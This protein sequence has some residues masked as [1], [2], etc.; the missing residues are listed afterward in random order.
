MSVYKIKALSIEGYMCFGARQVVHFPQDPGVYRVDG[1]NHIEPRLGSNG[2][3]KTK[4]LSAVSWVRYGKTT[5]GV[6]GPGIKSWLRTKSTK[7][8]TEVSEEG[9][10]N[11]EP[12]VIR[13]V[14]EPNSLSL[15]VGQGSEPRI[16]DQK[17]LDTF[18]EC[19]YSMFLAM[20][21]FPSTGESFMTIGQTEQGN[22]LSDVL[23]LDVWF[24]RSAAASKAAKEFKRKADEAEAQ[25]NEL[26]CRQAAHRA[27]IIEQQDL[28]RVHEAALVE[29]RQQDEARLERLREASAVK[30]GKRPVLELETPAGDAAVEASKCVD[31]ATAAL[32]A[33]KREAQ[34]ARQLM[35]KAAHAFEE[36][37]R[38]P[39]SK[40]YAC[41][42][43][44]GAEK[45]AQHTEKFEAAVHEAKTILSA[46]ERKLELRRTELAAAEAKH[47]EAAERAQQEYLE[48]QEARKEHDDLIAD[49]SAKKTKKQRILQDI[50]DLE[51]KEYVAFNSRTLD[52]SKKELT[53]DTAKI[54]ELSQKIENWRQNAAQHGFWAEGFAK[55]R[56]AE[57]ERACAEFATYM[58]S[59]FEVLG[60]VGWQ[61]VVSCTQELLSKE[62]RSKF[63]IKIKSP[64]SPDWVDW[65]SWSGG[66]K[67]RLAIAGDMAFADLA[68]AR[69]G[70]RSLDEFW[71]ERTD[72]LSREGCEDQMEYLNMRAASRGVSILAIDHR[73]GD[74]P[75]F[76]G[77][78]WI[79]RHPTGSKISWKAAG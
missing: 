8:M 49:W 22:K 62:T 52:R 41:D 30:I 67:H 78:I 58:L 21:L 32:Q 33:Q 1:F 34:R 14:Q 70:V 53:Q 31:V 42:S 25:V 16:V 24:E 56:M 47:H 76:K 10:K 5:D 79:D 13:R 51:A 66:Q 68:S 57:M 71:D 73:T 45:R 37:D 3:G 17:E 26:E 55:I 38:S 23:K 6:S 43:E 15:Q 28:Q 29:E 48:Q 19:D 18:L 7:F 39:R 64:S 50:T 4:L 11:G 74:S 2:S 40:C 77:L 12:Y 36:F 54:Q 65:K 63:N 69:S 60:L 35:E 20:T 75:V 61:I 27:T 72:T 9:T 44:I 59:A 46:E